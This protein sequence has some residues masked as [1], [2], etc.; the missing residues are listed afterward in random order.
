M[1]LCGIMIWISAEECICT[2]HAPN[3]Q[4]AQDGMYDTNMHRCKTISTHVTYRQKVCIT[5]FLNSLDDLYGIMQLVHL[6]AQSLS[7]THHA[8]LHF[9]LSFCF[10]S[11]F[12]FFFLSQGQGLV[13]FGFTSLLSWH[14]RIT[15]D[16]THSI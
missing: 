6:P 8:A 2:K 5:F 9:L 7:Q 12:I 3:T 1:Q 13:Y 4:H 16:V 14:Q 10:L 11:C 15:V